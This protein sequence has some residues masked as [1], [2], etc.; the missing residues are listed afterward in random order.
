MA[1]AYTSLQTRVYDGWIL[2]SSVYLSGRL[3][4]Q[5]PYFTMI[6]FGAITWHGLTVNQRTLLRLP[7]EVQNIVM[8][9]AAEYE[10]KAGTINDEKF[11]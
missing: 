8:E 10:A 11:D 6:G 3:H 7:K 5:A 4:E 2:F 1:E 9:V